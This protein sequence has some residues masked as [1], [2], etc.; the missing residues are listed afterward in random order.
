MSQVR[1]DLRDTRE[2]ARELRVEPTGSI[3]Q[4][5]VQ[6]A[7]EQLSTQ[8]PAVASTS[9]TTA[10]SPYAVQSSDNALYVDSTAGPVQILLQLAALRNGVPLV[11]KDVAGFGNTNNITITP[12]GG[13]TIDLLASLVINADFGGYQLNPR[14]ASYTLAP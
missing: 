4:T 7:L 11:V 13:Q 10:M 14:A 12:A 5:N 9:V 3:T 2:R 1:T 8:P 6:K